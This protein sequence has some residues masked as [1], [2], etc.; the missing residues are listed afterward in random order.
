MK[1]GII[2]I[3]NAFNYG[4]TLQAYALQQVLEELGH[5]VEIID[6][7]NKRLN[8]IYRPSNTYKQIFKSMISGHIR[9]GLIELTEQYKNRKD[10]V[11][12]QISK[13]YD[14]YRKQYL[15]LSKEVFSE[16]LKNLAVYDAIITGSDQVWNIEITGGDD[17]YYLK[18]P[19][20]NGKKISYAASGTLKNTLDKIDTV[21]DIRYISVREKQLKY[22]I[23]QMCAIKVTDTCDPTLL[24][25]KKYWDIQVQK[26]QGN[27]IFAYLMWDET[28]IID[29][30][31]RLSEKKKMPVLMVH[32]I[33]TDVLLN[34]KKLSVSTP[35]D[36]I[37]LIANAK[38]V[39]SN[40]FHGTVFSVIFNK[41]FQTF[42]SG[43]RV[44]D[45]L[46][47]LSLKERLITKEHIG[48]IDEKINWEDVYAII[49]NEK[50]KSMD[51]LKK[52]LEE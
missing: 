27:Y 31:M 12:I 7:Q 39:V 29:Y 20:F 5:D 19:N 28:F 4:S 36:F 18:I 33:Q 50:K 47:G 45:F 51:F 11:Y 52:S 44:N 43:S 10:N 17:I 30:L 23:E 6:Y 25:D 1:V 8:R 35:G 3:Q 42:A 21:K 9:S 15:K 24:L 34:G 48:N 32:R 37:N 13:K 16:G 14:E 38:Y 26:I 40:S 46:N 2:T 22:E 49:E 41:Q